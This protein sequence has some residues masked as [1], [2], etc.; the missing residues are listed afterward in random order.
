MS[1]IAPLRAYPAATPAAGAA[2]LG[3]R[4]DIEGLRAVA[5]T[6]VVL[7]HAGVGWLAG[8]YV[9]VDV[10]FVISGFLI[11][12]LLV[13]ELG[14]TG[15]VSLPGFYARRAV[16]LL[17]VSTVVLI[18]ALAGSWLWLPATRF[19]SISL[20]GL[21]STFYGINWRLAAEGV[22]YFNVGVAPSPLQ[23]LW[24]LAVEEQFYLVWPLLLLATRTARRVRLA[25]GALVVISLVVSVRQTGSSGPWAYFG[26]HTRAWELGVGA[27]VA[28]GTGTLTRTPKVVA[29]ALSWAGLGAVGVAALVFDARTAFPGYAALLPVLGAAAVIAAGVSA[30]GAGAG[31]LLGVWPLQRIGKLSYG[32]YLWHWPALMILPAALDHPP[33]L[34]LNLALAAGALVVAF[35]TYHLVEQP[36]R[37]R[38][39]LRARHRRG[40]A[41]GLVLSLTA[42]LV[43]G[44]AGRFTPPLP[45][46]PAAV[47]TA[48]ALAEAADPQAR[49]TQLITA[50][51]GAS[52]MPANLTPPVV[53]ASS[54]PPRVS[55]DLCHLNY[56]ENRQDRPCRYGDPAG[57]K[58]M[59]LIGDSHAGHWFPAFDEVAR[60]RGWQLVSLTKSACQ[61][62]SVLVYSVVFKRPY[63]ECV[64]WRDQVLDRI[65]AD[66]PDLV[67]MSS[68][69]L[70]NGGMIDA[71]GKAVPRAGLQDDPIWVQG[72]QRTWARLAGIP[73]VLL[74]DSPWPQGFAPECA[75]VHARALRTCERPVTTAVAE[76]NRRRL[77]AQAARRAGIKVIDPVP[78]FCTTRCP[79]V[80]G[81]TLVFKDN[82]HL[83]SAYARSLVPVLDRAIF[84]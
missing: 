22:D 1:T 35:G 26:S 41:L 83:T 20:D 72:W 17:P 4:P 58:V 29:V 84:S 39:R 75:V 37:T 13:K 54:D 7:S 34:R 63:T 50:S 19:R 53:A 8:G 70:D 38:I 46:G 42:A 67:V 57:T 14:R 45:Y 73:L 24:S 74:Q 71:A 23:H 28:V 16:R 61:M 10:F 31:R 49:L 65:I 82:S 21:F 78:W 5:V 56:V 40:L 30:G 12:T 51:I 25:L 68:N 81:N 2:H 66:R 69:D 33:T 64:Q 55:A 6:L 52:R 43:C 60:R 3:F 44:V 47:D 76:T 9:G 18:A 32:W 27:L 48:S 59:Y 62:P 80:I 11:T 77:T 36:A 79:I 15:T